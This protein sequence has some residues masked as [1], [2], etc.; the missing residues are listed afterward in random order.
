M[1]QESRSDHTRVSD[2]VEAATAEV[3]A[4][5]AKCSPQG[6]RESKMLANQTVIA[7]FDRSAER[8][9]DQSARLFFSAEAREGMAAFP[10]R[11]APRWEVR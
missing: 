5:L 8:L 1:R 2:D 11:R 4:S 6:L 3:C 10:Q 9:I 7:E